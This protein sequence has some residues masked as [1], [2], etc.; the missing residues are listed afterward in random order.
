MLPFRPADL[1]LPAKFREFRA[2][3]E[4]AIA[5]C[6]DAFVAGRRFVAPAMPPGSGKTLMYVAQAMLE[7]WRV[8]ILT[9]TKGLQDQLLDDFAGVGLV[10]IRGRNNYQCKAFT[11]YNCEDGAHFGCR[12]NRD[13][14][15]GGCPYRAAYQ[16]ALASRLVVTNYS[17]WGYIHR[18]GEGL[19]HFDLLVCDEA[20]DAPS[21]IC[22]VMQVELRR[23]EIEDMLRSQFPEDPGT[24]S[25][26]RWREWAHPQW[27][28]SGLE[29]DR[30]NERAK[31]V[32]SPSE[33]LARRVRE[34]KELTAKL[35]TLTEARGEW[36][37]EGMS[38]NK[39]GWRF[40]PLDAAPYSEE[41]LFHGIQRVMLISA[42]VREK[43]LDML[44]VPRNECWFHE[45]PSVF[46]SANWPIYYLPTVRLN[47]KSTKEDF[48]LVAA[49]A[50]N[51]IRTRSAEDYPAKGII[52]TVSF[53]RAKRLMEVSNYADIM[54]SHDPGGTAA[55]LEIARFR[56]CEPPAVL[57]S[58]SVSTGYD[59]PHES[60]H[61]QILPKLPYPDIGGAIMQARIT[62]DG[63]HLSYLM[64]QALVQ[65]C[66]RGMRA[67]DDF[68]EVFILDAGLGYRLMRSKHGRKTLGE[69]DWIPNPDYVLWPKYFLDQIRRVDRIPPVNPR[70]QQMLMRRLQ[71][72]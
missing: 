4:Q 2:Q 56:A 70:F 3:Q 5:Q 47:Q 48:G 26:A 37:R 18:Y 50:D 32:G 36:I 52:H 66:G 10:D 51:I 17:Y 31:A 19:G 33:G 71:D 61:F 53:A 6:T 54:V 59:F 16:A 43:T 64:V 20:H 28:R 60:C 12:F 62:Q 30:H 41:I 67:W 42:T 69:P 25:F 1:A 46:P 65:A 57:V 40:E 27:V 39:P 24:C 14:E 7:D 35:E 8:G 22:S 13:Q 58:P 34:W 11:D 21:Q 9:A 45:Y 63:Q 68:C 38:G 23:F 55:S 29:Y 15:L 72:A 44:G 49:M